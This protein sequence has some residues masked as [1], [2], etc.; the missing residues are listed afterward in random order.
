[1]N[2][3]K[4]SKSSSLPRSREMSKVGAPGSTFQSVQAA[5]MSERVPFGN[6]TRIRRTPRRRILVITSSDRPSNGCRLR[7][8]I[9]DSGGSWRWVVCR[10][11]L[12]PHQSFLTVPDGCLSHHQV[13]FDASSK[14]TFVC[15]ADALL[16]GVMPRAF[17]P[18]SPRGSLDGALFSFELTDIA[19]AFGEFGMAFARMVSGFV[20]IAM[21]ACGAL[22]APAAVAQ[23]VEDA[24]AL[25]QRAVEL[26][27]AGKGGD[28]IPL[29]KRVLELREKTLS[30]GH[31][32][33]ATSLNNLAFFYQE[34]GR[35]AEAEPLYK[36]ALELRE[37][38]LPEATSTS[39]SAST[40][41]RGSTRRR[42]ALLRL[43]IR[44]SGRTAK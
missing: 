32:D 31:P 30:A 19:V 42:A 17:A 21:L 6:I 39:R 20:I 25:E 10:V 18:T 4:R 36:W 7:V 13:L 26:Y 11:F 16:F 22:P 9:T 34:Q 23:P 29:A 5:A 15:L 33:I 14:V 28:A 35:L 41:W 40:A 1:M 12:H 2:A 3:R 24:D 38:A 27:R 44:P 37:K 43:M 8:L